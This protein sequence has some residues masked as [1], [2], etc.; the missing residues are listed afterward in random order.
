MATLNLN[1]EQLRPRLSH[2]SPRDAILRVLIVLLT[3]ILAGCNDV[4]LHWQEHA[5]VND[6]LRVLVERTADGEKYS[7][8]GGPKA[9]KQSEMTVEVFDISGRFA[10]LP[11]KWVGT[12]VPMIL[13]YEQEA[14]TWSLIATFSSCESWYEAGRPRPPYLEYQS[15]NGGHWTPVALEE[16]F[17]EKKANLLTGPR[18]D[19]EPRLVTDSD[20]ELRRRSAAPIF[21]SVLRT[22]GKEQENYCDTY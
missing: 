11:P 1:G 3:V 10:P 17:L 2:K 8:L 4:T 12:A 18:A 21:Q 16:R 9:W 19:G 20:K 13:D 7:E 15:K 5:D 22:W 6:E 14:G